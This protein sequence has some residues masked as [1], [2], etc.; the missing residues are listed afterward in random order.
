MQPVFMSLQFGAAKHP[1]ERPAK[2]PIKTLFM[3]ALLAA[4]LD[5]KESI[6]ICT[7]ISR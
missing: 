6:Q 1:N 5:Q 7:I 2:T 3:V 4:R